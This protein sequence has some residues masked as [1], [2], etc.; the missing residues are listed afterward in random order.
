MVSYL[1]KKDKNGL[2]L[3]G[4][5]FLNTVDNS[6]EKPKPHVILEYDHLKGGMDTM[7]QTSHFSTKMPSCHWLLAVF[8]S[9][10]D[11]A[12]PLNSYTLWKSTKSTANET[13]FGVIF[14]L[15]KSLIHEQQEI[16]A[17]SVSP[18]CNSSIDCYKH[19]C[20]RP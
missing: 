1:A 9:M 18:C 4:S 16:R 19:D 11:T 13:R 8:C 17:Q 3:T 2:L 12:A 10:L 5:N 15:R 6:T 7:N 20:A 14:S